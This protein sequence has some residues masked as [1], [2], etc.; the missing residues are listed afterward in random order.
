MIHATNRSVDDRIIAS[1]K[2]EPA[3]IARDKELSNAGASPRRKHGLAILG[4][5]RRHVRRGKHESTC[6]TRVTAFFDDFHENGPHHERP[7]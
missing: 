5:E 4:V 2:T 6:H 7:L 1:R 3:I